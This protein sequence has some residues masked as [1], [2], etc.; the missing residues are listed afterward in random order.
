MAGPVLRPEL[1]GVAGVPETALSD[2]LVARLPEEVPPA[3]WT[4]EARAVVWYARGS[5][6]ATEALPPSLRRSASGLA[7][8]GG[9]V[10]YSSTPVGPYDEVFGLVGSRTGIR[11]W[12]S[13]AFMSVDSEASLAGGR[14]NWA[15]PKTLGTFTGE[16]GSGQ[17]LTASG[18]D[19]STWRISVRPTAYGPRLPMRSRGRCRQEFPDGRLGESLMNGRG[20]IRLALV[21]VEVESDGPLPTWLRPG[22]HVGAVVESASFSMTEPAFG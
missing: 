18:A 6:A 10:R 19:A 13:V 1:T 3:P 22:R 16:V 9:V 21:D 15:M 4:C 5:A 7:V 12:G 20:R 8:V 11:P 14:G 2:A 17:T